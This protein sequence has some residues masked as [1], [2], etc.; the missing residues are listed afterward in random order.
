MSSDKKN[1]DLG[2][3]PQ[4][5]EQIINDELYMEQRQKESEKFYQES[6]LRAVEEKKRDNEFRENIAVIAKTLDDF[7]DAKIGKSNKELAVDIALK[8]IE[9]C[10]VNDKT[11]TTAKK[12]MFEINDII[13]IAYQKLEKLG[14]EIE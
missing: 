7:V 13:D 12:L 4:I 9:V 5:P 10:S 8:C 2:V 14:K 6:I 1:P 3:E 11:P